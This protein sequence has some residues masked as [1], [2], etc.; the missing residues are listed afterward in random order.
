MLCPIRYLQSDYVATC[1]K[2][3]LSSSKGS[4]KL[5]HICFNL[6]ASYMWTTFTPA[7]NIF[8][9]T[10]RNW[11]DSGQWS[12]SWKGKGRAH[13][14][15]LVSLASG[16]QKQRKKR[17]WKK[18]FFKVGWQ[19]ALEGVSRVWK[20]TLDITALASSIVFFKTCFIFSFG[21]IK[22]KRRGRE[23]TVFKTLL[24]YPNPI[25]LSGGVSEMRES[26]SIE[27]RQSWPWEVRWKSL[28]PCIFNK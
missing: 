20:L 12:H 18:F 22:I 1:S 17:K 19:L 26:T 21:A 23:T 27:F 4:R 28:K 6:C 2:F 15:R 10:C 3:T 14:N 7:N 9:L 16:R 5:N 8:H 24:D 25:C 13:P 11:K